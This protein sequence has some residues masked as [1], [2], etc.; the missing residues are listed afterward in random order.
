VTSRG[1]REQGA[2]CII[3]RLDLGFQDT[4]TNHAEKLNKAIH[5]FPLGSTLLLRRRRI[6][7]DGPIAPHGVG[8]SRLGKHC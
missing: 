7:R 1:P 2:F 3:F 5:G 6:L 8:I 4:G